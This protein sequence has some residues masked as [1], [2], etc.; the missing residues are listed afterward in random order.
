MRKLNMEIWDSEEEFVKYAKEF[1]GMREQ[2]FRYFKYKNIIKWRSICGLRL[3]LKMRISLIENADKRSDIS[4]KKVHNVDALDEIKLIKADKKKA[5]KD[6][7][8]EIKRKKKIEAKQKKNA[9]KARARK[10]KNEQL[11][12]SD[13]YELYVK[14]RANANMKYDEYL[15]SDTWQDIRVI[16]K[17]RFGGRCATCNSNKDLHVHHRTYKNRGDYV[18]ELNDLVL[19]CDKCHQMVHDN[20]KIK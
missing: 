13:N 20:N 14:H 10:K 17:D 9:K 8:K 12:N 1:L 16:V 3:S 15:K 5:Y 4:E 19:L 18:N 2:R 6:T 7:Q 11:M